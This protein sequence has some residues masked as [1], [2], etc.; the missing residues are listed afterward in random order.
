MQQTLKQATP[1]VVQAIDAALASLDAST[2]KRFESAMK[3][4]EAWITDLPAKS[5]RVSH[6]ASNHSSRRLAAT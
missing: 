2:T 6:C 4:F 5:V 1:L 3:C